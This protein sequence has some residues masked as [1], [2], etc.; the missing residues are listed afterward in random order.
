MDGQACLLGDQ[1]EMLRQLDQGLAALELGGATGVGP[2]FASLQRR[3]DD[4]FRGIDGMVLHEV[5]HPSHLEV[6]RDEDIA[7]KLS[8]QATGATTGEASDASTTVAEA[9]DA[10][11]TAAAA[12]AGVTVADA[13]DAVR[14]A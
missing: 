9:D 14:A 4:L 7:G 13:V 12:D 1:T 2:C 8:C 6:A 10:S 11:T 5:F 3:V